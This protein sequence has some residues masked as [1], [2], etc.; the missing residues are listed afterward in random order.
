VVNSRQLSDW[1]SHDSSLTWSFGQLQI[2]LS[3]VVAAGLI[4]FMMISGLLIFKATL[5]MM[6]RRWDYGKLK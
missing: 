6:R 3:L 4:F 2:I 1:S 5:E